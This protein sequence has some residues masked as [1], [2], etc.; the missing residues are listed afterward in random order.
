MKQIKN[1][2]WLGGEGGGGGENQPLSALLNYSND[3]LPN[4]GV[5]QE[6]KSSFLSHCSHANFIVY[7]T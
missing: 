4:K 6:V 3:L 2:F 7:G 5:L 1:N